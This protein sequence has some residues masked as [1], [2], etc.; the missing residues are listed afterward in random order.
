MNCKQHSDKSASQTWRVHGHCD[1][2]VQLF[3][4]CVRLSIE[5][6]P[7]PIRHT[8]DTLECEQAVMMHAQR[9]AELRSPEQNRPGFTLI[10]LLVVIAIIAILA[11]LLL[12]VLAKEI[13]TA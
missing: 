1:D 4:S 13:G 11:A 10:E 2:R 3:L 9:E 12:P 8:W 6:H 7:E 5:E